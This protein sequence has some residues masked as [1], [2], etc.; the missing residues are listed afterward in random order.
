MIPIIDPILAG[1][2]ALEFTF[3]NLKFEVLVPKV[4]GIDSSAPDELC[5]PAV[6]LACSRLL[7][8]DT[9]KM[10][11]G[12]VVNDL[13]DFLVA[14]YEHVQHKAAHLKHP[15]S[16][17]TG[18]CENFV[19]LTIAAYAKV[20]SGN[21]EHSLLLSDE[22]VVGDPPICVDVDFWLIKHRRA[23]ILASTPYEH[24]YDFGYSITV[25]PIK[26]VEKVQ[27]NGR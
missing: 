18:A 25:S 16:H 17:G 1:E 14:L 15:V 13:S 23:E 22:P 20:V 26:P 24:G 27:A 8:T 21:S 4:E 9:Q 19:R 7:D 3:D 6:R 5:I 11:I 12:K 2:A 10:K